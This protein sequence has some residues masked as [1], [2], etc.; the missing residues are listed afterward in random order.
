MIV[1][2]IT[3]GETDISK[4]VPLCRTFGLTASDGDTHLQ[5]DDI[6]TDREKI[7][8]IVTTFNTEQPELVHLE[9]ILENYLLDLNSF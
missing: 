5:I 2:E 6:T 1:F 8:F 4:G 7:E 3:S 9:E